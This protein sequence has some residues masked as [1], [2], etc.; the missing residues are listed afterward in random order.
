MTSLEFGLK[1]IYET[2]NYLLEEIKHNDLVS[3][4]HKKTCKYLNN[5]EQL[6][7]LASIITG[8]VSISAFTSLVA[9]P[10]GIISSAVGLKIYIINAGIKKYQSIIE[11][12]K[13]NH[14]IV[15]LG[16][17]KLDTIEV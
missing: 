5:F 10:I 17:T 8:C 14:R 2:R 7:I 3:E 16:K 9:V 1:K 12:E 15:L 13:K 6:L 11:K 4:K